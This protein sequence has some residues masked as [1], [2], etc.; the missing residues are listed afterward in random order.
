MFQQLSL[1][2]GP[3]I[4]EPFTVSQLTGHIRRLFEDDPVL[5][6]VWV[7]GEVSN[8]S[9]ASSGHCYFTLKDAGAQVPCVMWRNVADVQDYL[10]A[11]GDLVLAHGSVSVY[12]AGGRYQLYVDRVQPSGEDLPTGPDALLACADDLWKRGSRNPADRRTE[13]P[14]VYRDRSEILR[15]DRGEPRGG[16][17]TCNDGA[18]TGEHQGA[19][20]QYPHQ[21]AHRGGRD[22]SA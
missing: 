18:R 22:R 4:S 11:S 21:F 9:R 14:A 7:E 5:D 17:G 8:F 15:A 1:F 6:N 19:F 3:T 2:G 12:E 20:A 13:L 16:A 10:P